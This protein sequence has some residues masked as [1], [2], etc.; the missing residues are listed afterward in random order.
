MSAPRRAV[1]IFAREPVPGRTKTRLARDIGPEAAAAL[2]RAFVEDLVERL[3]EQF[4]VTVFSA[5]ATPGPILSELAF[6]GALFPVPVLARAQGER[7]SIGRS[8]A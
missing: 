6:Y 5:E 3:G 7:R 1:G 2:A 4:Q 8:D